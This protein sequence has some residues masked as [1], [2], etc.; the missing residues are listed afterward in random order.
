[1]SFQIRFNLT[2]RSCFFS[3][4]DDIDRKKVLNKKKNL[5]KAQYLL[6][7]L[8]N[9]QKFFCPITFTVGVINHSVEKF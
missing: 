2:V 1:M 7:K 5:R 4:M 8:D 9:L 6:G 3:F